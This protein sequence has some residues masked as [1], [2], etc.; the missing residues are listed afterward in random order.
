MGMAQKRQTHPGYQSYRKSGGDGSISGETSFLNAVYQC[1]LLYVLRILCT[2][3][4]GQ[5]QGVECIR[6]EFG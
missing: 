6:S 1:V 4:S 3:D 5:Q 2:S